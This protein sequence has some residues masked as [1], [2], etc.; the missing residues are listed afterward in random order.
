MTKLSSGPAGLLRILAFATLVFGLGFVAGAQTLGRSTRDAPTPGTLGASGDAQPIV[1]GEPYP[2]VPKNAA[3][4]Q[5]S[6]APVVATTAPAVVNVYARRA[7]RSPLMAD[8][9]FRNLFEQRGFGAPQAQSEASLGS[10]VIIRASGIIVTNAHV[11]ANADELRVVLS[12]RR[13]YSASVVVADTRTDLAVLKLQDAPQNLPIVNL[14][15]SRALKVGDLVIAIGNP[16]GVGQTVTQGIVSALSRT[17]TGINDIG[18]FIQTDAPINPGNSGGALVNLRGELVGINSAI[19]SSSGG[20]N[21]IGFAIPSELV[22]RVVESAL[23]EGRVVRTWLGIKTQSVT[24]EIAHSLKL[25]APQGVLV[26]DVYPT[27][28]GAQ[29]GL[30]RGDVILSLDDQPIYGDEGQRFIASTKRPG[31]TT[32]MEILRSGARSTLNARIAAIPDSERSTQILGGRQPFSGAEV[33]NISPAVADELGVDLFARGVLVSR[34]DPRSFAASIRLRP[35]DIIRSIN[36]QP[37]ENVGQ[38]QRVL[39]RGSRNWQVEI[40]RA[41]ETLRAQISL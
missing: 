33:L 13:E 16:F 23:T 1:A 41:G 19:L 25:S 4:I 11:V 28:P 18:S 36:G 40:E 38:L 20:S 10:G 29:A 8:P 6:F 24:Q 22:R 9:F 37:I 30:R 31:E 3:E 27:G 17:E 5:L 2:R 7:Q 32:K 15:S 14:A 12:D 26:A 35:G 34:I 39:A 21:G